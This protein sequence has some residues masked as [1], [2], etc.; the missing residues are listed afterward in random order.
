MGRRPGAARPA[1]TVAGSTPT[2]GTPP[3]SPSAARWWRSTCPGTATRRGATTPTTGPRRWRRR[4]ARCWRTLAPDA[5]AVVGQSLGGLTAIAVAAARPELVRRLVIVDV[6]PGIVVE[7]GNQV[8]D[9]LAGPE[10]FESRDE[11]VERAASFGFGVSRASLERGV[12]HNTRVRDDGRVVF[13]HHLANLG[14]RDAPFSHRL[15]AAVAGPRGRRRAGAA[16]PRQPRLPQRRPRRRA[17]VDR[18]PGARAVTI[19]AGHNVQEDAPVELAGALASFLGRLIALGGASLVPR[20]TATLPPGFRNGGI[21]AGPGGAVV[22]TR[23]GTRRG[24]HRGVGQRA[25]PGPRARRRRRRVPSNGHG[26]SGPAP[27]VGLVV[28][29]VTVRFGGIVALDQVMLQAVPGEIT[30]LIGPTAPGRRRC[31]TA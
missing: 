23:Q 19:D 27:R 26:P 24:G 8:R 12:L 2:R 16:R 15:P 11:I 4:W 30:G 20:V 14:D 31:S 9:F 1:R 22:T 10:S 21:P 7:G 13:K 18:V 17:H 5:E 25:A 3:L 28:D 29:D 6:S